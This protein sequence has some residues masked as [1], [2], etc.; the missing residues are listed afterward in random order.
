MKV[1]RLARAELNKLF[2]RPAIFLMAGFLVVALVLVAILYNPTVRTDTRIAYEGANTTEIHTQFQ[3]EKNS[4]IAELSGVVDEINNFTYNIN[5]GTSKLDELKN[6]I[7]RAEDSFKTFHD[8][9][10]YAEDDENEQI[11]L[12][13]VKDNLKT[14]KNLVM[15]VQTYLSTIETDIDFYITS[16]QLNTLKRFFERLNNDLP[17]VTTNYDKDDLIE[18]A[19]FLNESRNFSNNVYS[20]TNN[21]QEI[22]LDATEIDKIVEDYYYNIVTDTDSKLNVYERQIE[23]YYTSHV[24]SSQDEDIEALNTMFSNY[25]SIVLMAKECLENSYTLL[26]TSNLSNSALNSY[27]GFED[28]NKYTIEETLTKNT[29]LLNT[30]NYDIDFAN[31]FNFGTT[32]GFETSAY[33]FTIYAMQILTFIIAVFCLF[34]GSGLIAG[35]HTGKTMKMLAI[36]PYTR[37]KIYLGKFVACIAF[38][39][40]LLLISF[41]ASF[42][43]GAVMFGV[44]LPNVLLVIN[45][46]Q[47]AVVHPFV[48]MLIYLAS[49]ILNLIFYISLALLLSVIFRSSTVAV[50]TSFIVYVATVLCNMLMVGV[51]WF[52]WLPIAHL[53]IFKYFGGASSSGGFLT[54]NTIIDGSLGLSLGYLLGI[55]LVFNLASLIVFKKRNIA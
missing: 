53:D 2:Q 25:K 20:I 23:E 17:T 51:S 11:N 24:G 38:M 31:N 15:E 36:R 34:F 9:L 48:V 4:I 8:S 40:I 19:N 3:S 33:D 54:F 5:N 46:S 6:K 35:E 55:I 7:V 22:T 16:N 49:C 44:N 13:P 21:L 28:I 32:A 12:T 41:V 42:I 29:Y 27:V 26:K 43:V 45:A 1:F 37:N 18:L 14:F 52:K 50:L 10:L 39:L 30:G 47:V